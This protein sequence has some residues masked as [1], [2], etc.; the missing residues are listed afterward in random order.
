METVPCV[1]F[2]GLRQ[3][4]EHNVVVQVR[5]GANERAEAAKMQL[6]RLNVFYCFCCHMLEREP[7]PATVAVSDSIARK[8]LNVV[9][10]CGNPACRAMNRDLHMR[11]QYEKGVMGRCCMC[12]TKTTEHCGRCKHVFY[13]S[14]DCQRTD[15][16]VHRHVCGLVQEASR[17]LKKEKEEGQEPEGKK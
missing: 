5:E 15:W 1:V 16:P 8:K 14:K 2:H 17:I 12:A 9:M 7:Q 6:L 13:C 3:Q 10:L 11:A 4:S